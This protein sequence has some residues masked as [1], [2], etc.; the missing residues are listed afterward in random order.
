MTCEAELHGSVTRMVYSIVSLMCT[1]S[2][3]GPHHSHIPLIITVTTVTATVMATVAGAVKV[4]ATG[5][6]LR[7]SSG[8]M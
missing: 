5:T 8:Q 2:L 1:G 4:E 7:A 6:D 3:Q